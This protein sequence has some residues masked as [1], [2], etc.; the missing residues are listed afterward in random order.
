M[1]SYEDDRAPNPTIV[2]YSNPNN[3]VSKGL[4]R[5]EKKAAAKEKAKEEKAK[6]KASKA[7]AKSN[8]IAANSKANA[9]K[10][11]A[12]RTHTKPTPKV[13]I[14]PLKLDLN[15]VN[16]PKRQLE[17]DLNEV[18]NP[19]RQMTFNN[20][21]NTSVKLVKRVQ[22]KLVPKGSRKGTSM[23]GLVHQLLRGSLKTRK[24]DNHKVKG[25]PMNS[26]SNLSQLRQKQAK[27]VKTLTFKDRKA[28]SKILEKV[29]RDKAKNELAE[30]AI[31]NSPDTILA[32][33]LQKE[34]QKE[35]EKQEK[36][37]IGDEENEAF[38]EEMKGFHQKQSVA[39]PNGINLNVAENLQ[40]ISEQA[41]RERAAPN[42]PENTLPSFPGLREKTPPKARPKRPTP[43]SRTGPKPAAAPKP[44]GRAVPRRTR[45]N[46]AP[47][48]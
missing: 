45:Q 33:D 3:I 30:M 32:R 12:K 29:N 24:E 35:Q 9:N 28:L 34:Y 25:I 41:E 11:I 18:N 31:P 16:N 38:Y 4:S 20:V 6:A 27:N 46:T 40:Y 43:K 5:K 47:V 17:L 15:E 23:N 14:R 10:A 21:R 26:I 2:S 1:P 13:R 37:R 8:K 48:N 39:E 19:K 22:P 42:S 36:F 7:K 44:R